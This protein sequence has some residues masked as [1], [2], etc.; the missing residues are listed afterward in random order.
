[1]FCFFASHLRGRASQAV[2]SSAHRGK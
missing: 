1:L 2:T